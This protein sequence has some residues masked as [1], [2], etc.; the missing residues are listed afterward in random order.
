VR[1]FLSFVFRFFDLIFAGGVGVAAPQRRL[2]AV[3][4]AGL[5]WRF[6]LDSAAPCSPPLPTVTGAL[7]PPPFPLSSL[8][9]PSPSCCVPPNAPASAPAEI[10]RGAYF[11]GA[12]RLDSPRARPVTSR[13]PPT[14][15]PRVPSV[16]CTPKHKKRAYRTS[17][18][19]Q[20]IHRGGLL[21]STRQG[22]CSNRLSWATWIAPGGRHYRHLV[23]RL[24]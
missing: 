17:K 11:C 9:S 19:D 21:E 1:A 7:S 20:A 23:V 4:R 22:R 24:R 13:L 15:G 8:P 2:C 3:L 5:C 6:R 12:G 10:T 18:N 16:A 14:A